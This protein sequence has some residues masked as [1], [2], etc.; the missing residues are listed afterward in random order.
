MYIRDL[1]PDG[2]GEFTWFSSRDQAPANGYR[3]RRRSPV[4]WEGRGGARVYIRREVT[5]RNGEVATRNGAGVGFLE[6]LRRSGPESALSLLYV[7]DRCTGVQGP[8]AL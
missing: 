4:P 1:I 3:E 8:P 6:G 2:S 7:Q 5:T